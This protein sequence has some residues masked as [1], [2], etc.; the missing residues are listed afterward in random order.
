MKYVGGD[1][2]SICMDLTSH[3]HALQIQRTTM[4]KLR[5]GSYLRCL[6]PKQTLFDIPELFREVHVIMMWVLEA[7][8]LFPQGSDLLLTVSAYV[9]H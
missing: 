9:V 2:V 7:F 1:M 6:F 8:D 5:T 3:W 4:S